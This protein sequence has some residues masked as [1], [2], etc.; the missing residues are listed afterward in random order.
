MK[1]LTPHIFKGKKFKSP[2]FFL[3]PLTIFLFAGVYYVTWLARPDSFI[4]NN[5]LNTTPLQNVIHLASSRDEYIT[6]LMGGIKKSDLDERTNK[7]INDFN[8]TNEES[9]KLH[10]LIAE[11]KVKEEPLR[12]QLEKL[13]GQNSTNYVNKSTKKL[14]SELDNKILEQKEIESK[15][16]V[17]NRSEMASASALKAIEIQQ[18]HLDIAIAKYSA[19]SYVLAHGMEF[20][21]PDTL[22]KIKAITKSTRDARKKIES[23]DLKITSIKATAYQLAISIRQ[24]NLNYIDFLYYSV[25]IAT[26]TTFGDILAN[27]RIIR[28]FVCIQLLISI[29]ILS[30]LTQNFLSKN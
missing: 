1:K 4:K 24:D 3:Y 7:L 17:S 27:D 25:G 15:S 22:S 10:E 21:D 12:S 19:S 23:N 9:K 6:P 13:W 26:T 14:E 2:V 5:E 8:T 20:H 11:N 18:A 29:L 16:T 30:K 28:L